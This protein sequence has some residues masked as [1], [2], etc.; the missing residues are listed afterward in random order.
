MNPRDPWSVFADDKTVLVAEE[1][2]G[3]QPRWW[4]TAAEMSGLPGHDAPSGKPWWDESAT[5]SF[6]DHVALDPNSWLGIA[7]FKQ[8]LAGGPPLHVANFEGNLTVPP[9]KLIETL[10]ESLQ[11]RPVRFAYG[12][13]GIKRILFSSD[14]SMLS[15]GFEDGGRYA[16]VAIASTKDEAF[17]NVAKLC[18]G[19]LTHDNPKEGFVYALTKG[20]MGGYGLSRI[21]AAG[22]PLER[23]NYN[24][25]VLA[26]YDHIVADLK[27]EAPCGRL[28]IMAG[29]PGTGKTYLVRSLLSDIPKAAFV[30]VPPHMVKELGSPELLPALAGAR[31]DGMSG[32][33]ALIIEDAD[34]VLVQREAGDMAAISSLL[35]LGDGILGSVLDVRIIATT[36]AGSLEMDPATRRKGRL[37]AYVDVG[38]VEPEQ[39]ETIV[40]RLMGASK[41]P[42]RPAKRVTLADVYSH[43][44]ELGWTP[45][46]KVRPPSPWEKSYIL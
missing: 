35:N 24:P 18:A 19:I 45:P 2:R 25:K 46:P 32:P 8:A 13:Q 21:G 39:A 43:A 42:Q 30:V 22:T 6:G 28:I 36:N 16:D 33:M 31:H 7:M 38:T 23:G 5:P 37:C 44:R 3:P 11:L 17:K 40:Q 4:R 9:R 20:A 1:L 15:L 26:A 27:A 41:G 10:T 14:V 12:R 34:K 29:E